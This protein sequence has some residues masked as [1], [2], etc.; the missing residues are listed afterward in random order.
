MSCE[1]WLFAVNADGQL[2][3]AADG[4]PLTLAV[5]PAGASSGLRTVGQWQGRGCWALACEQLPPPA[6]LLP[7]RSR[8]GLWPEPLFALAGRARQLLEFDANH[9]F[10]GYCATTL[11]ARLDDGGRDCPACGLS[12][13]PRISPCVIVAVWRPGEIL[14]AHHVRHASPIHTVLAGFIEAG[15]SAE[16]AA[17]REVAEEVG[18]RIGELRYCGSQPWPFPHS[19]MLGFTARWLEG[20]IQLDTRELNHAAWYRWDQLPLLPPPG[21]IALRLIEQLRRG[22]G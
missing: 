13:Y 20:E 22:Q 15:E 21:T 19:L 1:D 3:L 11:N 14:L 16:Q 17:E 7:L 18:I 8:L 2:W 6:Q 12:V 10:C 4:Q 9:R 5:L